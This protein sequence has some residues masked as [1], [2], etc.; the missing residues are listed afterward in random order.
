MN[1]FL[2]L[3]KYITLKNFYLATGIFVVGIFFWLTQYNHPSADDYNY[4]VDR[5]TLGFWQLQKHFYF[6]WTGR[7]VATFLLSSSP[8]AYYSFFGYKIIAFLLLAFLTYGIYF[9]IKTILPKQKTIDILV[10]SLFIMLLV[11]AQMPSIAQGIYWAAGALTYQTANIFTLFLFANILRLMQ[12]KQ[13]KYLIFAVIF[14]FL[15]I[16]SNE[17]S[18]LLIDFLVFII[19]A[20]QLYQ[21]RKIDKNLFILLAFMFVFSLI[22]ILAPGNMARA[23]QHPAGHQMRAFILSYREMKKM[24]I[25]WFPLLILLSVLLFDYLNKLN[26][27]KAK[28]FNNHPA[29]GLLLLPFVVFLGYFPGYWSLGHVP[30]GRTVNVIYFFFVLI[31]LFFLLSAHYRYH[32]FIQISAFVRYAVILT[33]FIFIS[34]KDNNIYIAYKD[35]D[36]ERAYWYDIENYDRY[37]LIKKSKE[38]TIYLK[39]YHNRPKTLLFNDITQDPKHWRNVSFAKYWHKKVI[40]LEKKTQ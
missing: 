38:D 22:S 11:L 26:I 2:F 24:I 10:I 13:K 34:K 17:T 4:T 6:G 7:Y 40:V 15:V 9:L 30:P 21:H 27:S 37:R 19:F 14:A 36:T 12:T 16:G 33:I 8:L 35:I 5:F 39:K 25:S 29:F 20:Y 3:S 32:K 1:R 31:S 28:F 18:M 23:E